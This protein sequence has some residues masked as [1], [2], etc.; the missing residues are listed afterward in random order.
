MLEKSQDIGFSQ[1]SLPHKT[2]LASLE[3]ALTQALKLISS[4]YGDKMKN[5]ILVDACLAANRSEVHDIN[6]EMQQLDTV[7]EEKQSNDRK[8][9]YLE[10]VRRRRSRSRS[11]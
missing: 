3:F 9:I 1:L 7:V 10:E 6:K 4:A 5:K 8:A 11:S 2:K